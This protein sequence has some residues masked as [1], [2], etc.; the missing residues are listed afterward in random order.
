[1]HTVSTNGRG[2]WSNIE[3]KVDID[4][5]VVHWADMDINDEPWRSVEVRVGFTPE[6][7]DINEDG[8]IYTDTRFTAGVR[9][10]LKNRGLALISK[11]LNYTEQGMQGENYVSMEITLTDAQLRELLFI[12]PEQAQR[13]SKVEYYD[14][15]IT[16][17]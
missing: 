5:I 15:Q 16:V 1:M 14:Y 3:R 11:D 17:K 4:S 10:I 9:K 8:L 7:W 2:L 12:Y 6:T 13:K